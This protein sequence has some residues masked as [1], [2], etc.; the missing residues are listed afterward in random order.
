MAKIKYARDLE[1][2][3]YFDGG[4][5]ALKVN[6]KGTKAVWVDESS[7]VTITLKGSKLAAFDENPGYLG[8]GKFTSATIVDGEDRLVFS[9]SDVK[10][11][12]KGL[13]DAYDDNGSAGVAY[14]LA[15]GDDRVIGSNKSQIILGGAGD[16]VLTGKGGSDYFIFQGQGLGPNKVG[17]EYD[18][19]TDFTLKGE[20]RDTLQ[21]N[22]AYTLQKKHDNTDTLLK[23]ED[24]STLLLEGVKK[25][26][27]QDY[28]D[29]W[30]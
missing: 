22:M 7:N 13:S 25:A 24:G 26:Q 20:D 11:K 18:V 29:S 8:A 19:I 30:N 9:V 28:L 1:G 12:A 16:D 2:N 4:D 15:Q 27:F 5:L 17:P 6:Q 23:F 3:F 10:L 21:L 14:F